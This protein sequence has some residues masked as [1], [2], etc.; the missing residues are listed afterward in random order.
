MRESLLTLGRRLSLLGLAAIGAALAAV[1]FT[2][3]VGADITYGDNLA[4]YTYES[5]DCHES[6]AEVLD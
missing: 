1:A 5:S 6:D 2:S 4:E 3:I